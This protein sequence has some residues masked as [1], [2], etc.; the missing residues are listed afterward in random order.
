MADT[1]SAAAEPKTTPAK[2]ITDAQVV[3]MPTP[4]GSTPAIV[5]RGIEPK[6]GS[7]IKFTLGNGVTYTGTVADATNADGE[8]LVEFTDGILPVKK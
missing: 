4:T 3:A 7:V 2:L 6:K 5:Y 8:V 1:K